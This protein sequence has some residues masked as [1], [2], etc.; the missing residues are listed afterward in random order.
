VISVIIPT[1]NEGEYL[2]KTLVA[3]KDQSCQDFEIIVSDS[4]S[5]D[6]TQEIAKKYGAKLV[7]SDRLGPAVGRN[8]GARIAKGEILLFLDADTIPSRAAL[9]GIDKIMKERKDVVG[10]TCTFYPFEGGLVDWL[11]FALANAAARVMIKSGVPQDPGNC[12]FYRRKVFEK[13][14]GIREDLKLN[15]TH[16]LAL[17]TRPYGNFVYI[18]APAFTSVRRYRKAGYLET[19]RIYI[20]ATISYFHK[21]QVPSEKFVFEPVR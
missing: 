12:G 1:L 14:G 6:N 21:K 15:E 11:I 8:R 7:L 17:R 5:D 13:I 4:R 16:D 9:E 18:R 2:E 19:I 10:G 3:L 20:N